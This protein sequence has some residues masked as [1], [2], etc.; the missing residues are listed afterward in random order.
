MKLKAT[1]ITGALAT[2]LLL[3]S[4]AV[5]MAA[6]SMASDTSVYSAPHGDEVDTIDRGD[7]VS[8][9][10]CRA[11]YCFVKDLDDSDTESGWVKSGAIDFV[12]GHDDD[13]ME[14]T[15]VNDNG[16]LVDLDD[17]PDM[18]MGGMGHHKHK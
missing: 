6:T 10:Q 2:A 16:S 17:V 7:D 5:A 12:G 18:P 8:V 13:D 9:G 1:L 11:G 3:A 4:G 15:P 14:A